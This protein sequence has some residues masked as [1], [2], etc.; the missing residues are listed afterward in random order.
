MAFL[1]LPAGTAMLL[2]TLITVPAAG[3]GGLGRLSI[4]ALGG[5]VGGGLLFY[6]AP[7]FELGGCIRRGSRVFTL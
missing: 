7:D 3:R 2:S 6:V 4:L 1:L 5:F